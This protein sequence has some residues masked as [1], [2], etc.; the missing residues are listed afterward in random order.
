[1]TTIHADSPDGAVEQ[2][3]LLVLQAGSN[4]GRDDIRHY[5]RTTVDVFVTLDR[6]GGR[7][8]VRDISLRTT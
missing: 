6:T 5:V 7:R 2:L 1:M 3:T 4:L 8:R